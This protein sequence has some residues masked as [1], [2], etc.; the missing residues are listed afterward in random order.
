[1]SD[2]VF[3]VGYYRSG[4]SALSGALAAL[5]VKIYNDADPNEHNPLGFYEIPELID[6]DVNLFAKL[7]VEWTDVRGLQGGWVERADLAPF[8]GQLEGIV[9]QRFGEGDK[10]WG[11]KH[12]HLCRTLP[13]YERVVRQA[14]HRPHVVHVFRDPWTAAASQQLKNGLSRAH[15]LLLWMSYATSAE[16]VAR[17]LPRSW[18]TYHELL[19]DPVAQIERID[20]E[21]GLDLLGLRPEGAQAAAAYFTQRL[22]R[23][24]PL[25]ARQVFPPLRALVERTWEMICARDLAPARWDAL[26]AETAE[27]VAFLTEV[28]ASKG[29]VIPALGGVGGLAVTPMVGAGHL[30]PPERLDEGGRAMLARQVAG[31]GRLPSVSVVVVA[32]AG[33]AAAISE[34][35]EAL[36][37]QI[38]VKP[39][40][41]VLAADRVVLDSARVVTVADEPEAATAAVCRLLNEEARESDYVA[42]I[43][44]GDTVAV[45]AC[46]RFALTAAASA[47]DMIYCDEV[48]PREGGDWVRYKPAWDVTRLRQA[49][50]IGDWVWYAG[51]A[52]VALGGFNAAR[53]GAEEYDF[54]LRLAAAGRQVVRLPETLFTRSAGARRDDIKT[55]VFCARAAE[56]VK[57][58]LAEVGLA[59]EVQGRQF[60]GLFHHIRPARGGG[61][62]ILVGCDKVDVK[63]LDAFLTGLLTGAVLPGPVILYGTALLPEVR[64]YLAAV[65]AQEAAL[66]GQVLAV[67]PDHEGG[68]EARLRAALAL[69]A[70]AFVTVIDARAAAAQPQWVERL[71]LRLDD[72]RVGLVGGR[73]LAVSLNEGR[74]QAFVQGPIVVGADT[75]LGAGHGVDDPG[76]GGWLLVDQEVSAVAPPGLM[77]RRDALAA[78]HFADL[79]GDALWIDLC[80]QLRQ[81]GWAIVWTPD[82]S[83]L[84][85]PEVVEVDAM[86]AFRG[87]SDVARGLGWL[88]PFHHPALSLHGDLLA[89]ETRTGLVRAAPAEPCSVVISGDPQ[90]GAA[91]LNAARAAR[92][93]GMVEA[94]WVPELPSAG[95]IGRRA[96]AIWVRVNPE[97]DAQPGSPDYVAVF[98]ALP[99]DELAG[100]LAHMARAVA[101]SPGLA[102][103]VQKLCP[104]GC[105]VELWRPALSRHVWGDLEFGKGMNSRP[106]ILWVDEGV[107]PAWMADLIQA[108][109][110]LASWI[111]V[112]RPGGA[113]DGAMGRIDPPESEYAWAKTLAELGPH[114]MVRPVGAEPAL[115]H[116][117]ALLAA[118]AGCRLLVDDRLDVP[119]A[120]MPLQLPNRLAAWTEAVKQAMADLPETLAAGK[121]TREA[122]LALPPIEATLPDWMGGAKAPDTALQP[123]AE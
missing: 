79:S 98:S 80:A 6:F 15:A 58:H 3:V 50:Y 39:K 63:T 94:D 103:R 59:S 25:D 87:G 8:I 107:A 111:V 31:C 91:V 69:A 7:G 28:G 96:P 14:G 110:D 53:A 12:P 36:K 55:D 22:N 88:D 67:A 64:E 120:L 27:I 75:R 71:R 118:A 33:R 48:V 113:Y 57:A 60:V 26:A 23:S 35:L 112:Q 97:R 47:P 16:A 17:H 56:A 4:T 82:V 104:P 123:A 65:R 109:L 40:V 122:A 89:A 93:T 106:R 68:S 45:D 70:T 90:R 24:A 95:D 115:D 2:A 66:G 85:P 29:R 20:R 81:R 92:R 54:Q 34:T 18:V 46:A 49:A 100:G 21:L 42:V 121:R 19:A 83:F 73:T 78:C 44:A 116:Y 11:L 101:T 52:V 61:V 10:V 72:E 37:G 77:A 43:N 108:T 84:A 32:P 38:L 114:L 117:P 102:T 74:Q 119:A 51:A 62:S 5:G 86:G 1:M 30:R 76:P 99:G 13:I 41:V 9:R 105:T